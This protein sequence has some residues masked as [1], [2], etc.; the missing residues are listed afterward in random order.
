MT[1]VLHNFC[2]RLHIIYILLFNF[3]FA[4]TQPKIVLINWNFYILVKSIKY[5]L[6]CQIHKSI[7]INDF[8]INFIKMINEYTT[9]LNLATHSKLWLELKFIMRNN[10]NYLFCCFFFSSKKN[11]FSIK[12]ISIWVSVKGHR[13][14]KKKRNK[15]SIKF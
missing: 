14:K 6:H 13:Y 2:R 9:P 5:E 15:K 7:F 3:F 12:F 1:D 10:D 11:D 4:I 8:F